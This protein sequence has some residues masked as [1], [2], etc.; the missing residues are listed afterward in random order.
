MLKNINDRGAWVAQ[1]VKR[2][3]SAQG[4]ISRS[5]DRAPHRTPCLA[6]SLLLPLPLPLLTAPAL[7]LAL[8]LWS[9]MNLKKKKERENINYNI[10]NRKC[11]NVVKCKGNFHS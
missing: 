1:M 9:Q 2:L 6:G 8:Y 10:K 3:P 11:L 7:S 5:W 4:M